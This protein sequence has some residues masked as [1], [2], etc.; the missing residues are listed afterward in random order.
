[1]GGALLSSHDLGAIVSDWDTDS[2]DCD[3]KQDRRSDTDASES[4]VGEL[5][6]R[7]KF[8]WAVE[9]LNEV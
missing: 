6:I 9:G 7:L 4:H 1:M 5:G 8:Y 3:E 2:F